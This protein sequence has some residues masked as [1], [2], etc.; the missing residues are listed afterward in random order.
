VTS[1]SDRRGRDLPGPGAAR[2]LGESIEE[3]ARREALEE[4]GVRGE[5]GLA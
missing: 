4:A 3:A 1:F 2:R 5:M